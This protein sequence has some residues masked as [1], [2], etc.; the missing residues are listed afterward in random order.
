[1]NVIFFDFLLINI[2]RF[3]LC[4]S[5]FSIILKGQ[6]FMLLLHFRPRNYIHDRM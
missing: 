3:T 1:M 6:G 5:M 4:P 2:L